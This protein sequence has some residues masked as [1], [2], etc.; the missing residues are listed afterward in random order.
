[1]RVLTAL[2]IA[3]LVLPLASGLAAHDRAQS[4]LPA[5]GAPKPKAPPRHHAQP[6]PGVTVIGDSV[7]DEISSVSSAQL[8][9]RRGVRLH[10]Q[11][12]ACRRLVEP[13]CTVAGVQ[14]PTAL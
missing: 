11:L 13:S 3:L 8:V 6:R 4:P 14:P 12:A 1:M 10:L 7:A 2:A 9:H 5:P